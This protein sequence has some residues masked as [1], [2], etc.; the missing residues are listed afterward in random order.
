MYSADAAIGIEMTYPPGTPSVWLE[1]HGQ[2]IPPEEVEELPLKYYMLPER[3]Q[4]VLGNYWW[5]VRL[6]P[7]SK[8][9][10][11]EYMPNKKY[12]YSRLVFD[13]AQD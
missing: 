7:N 12:S 11:Y 10:K 9:K 3:D 13:F 5:V 6:R 4:T 2:T 8:T 1:I